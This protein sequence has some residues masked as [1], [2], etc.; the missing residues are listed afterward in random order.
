MGTQVVAAVVEVDAVGQR[1]VV[2]ER[3]RGF[4]ASDQH[5]SQSAVVFNH[6][7]K[8]CQ[9][10]SEWG[11]GDDTCGEPVYRLRTST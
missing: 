8:Q 7:S 9:Q 5:P 6:V 10:C 3:G 11:V 4:S 1:D 2:A